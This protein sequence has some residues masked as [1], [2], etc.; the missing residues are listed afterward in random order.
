[1]RKLKPD[2]KPDHRDDDPAEQDEL[3]LFFE[4]MEPKILFSADAL[5][6]LAPVD[7]L[8]DNNSVRG[9]DVDQSA[10]YL[11]EAYTSSA[12]AT[13]NQTAER[14]TQSLALEALEALMQGQDPETDD[15]IGT[16]LRDTVT[17][18][19]ERQE[20]IF[21]DAATPDYQ[22]LLRSIKT[23]T[24]D[25]DYQIFLLNSQRDGIEQ[26]S[27]VLGSLEGIDAVHLVSHGNETGFQLGDSWVDQDTL[28]ASA[29][30]VSGW[31]SIL[32]GDADILIYG[33]NLAAGEPGLQLIDQLAGL[34][35]ADVAA[36]TDLTGAA[37]LGG[38]WDLEHHSGKIESLVAFSPEVQSA[39][40]GVLL[41]TGTAIWADTTT[42]GPEEVIT[43]DWDGGS[44]SGTTGS[45]T[46]VDHYRIMQGAEAP[47]RDE[48][49]VVGIQNDGNV[50]GIIWDGASWDA[51]P[52]TALS[53]TAVTNTF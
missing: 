10:E 15:T 6:G 19:H 30:L 21:V 8:D 17:P 50:G 16:F 51:I 3:S 33:C 25:T 11:T 44:F 40:K 49:I 35:G 43:D 37:E 7:P 13:D 14:D 2:Q 28:S 36:S 27:Q 41:N 38:D 18:P 53:G 22:Q 47:D 34:T 24:P 42:T 39:W 45:G 29:D 5:S 32:K 31:S 20:V 9:L 4:R 52:S 23:D 26:I 1:M 46:V 48:K 12:D